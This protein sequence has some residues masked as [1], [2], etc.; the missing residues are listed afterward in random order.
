MAKTG[1]ITRAEVITTG[2]MIGIHIIAYHDNAGT[3]CLRHIQRP[4]LRISRR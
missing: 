2:S 3:G 4:T 1:A